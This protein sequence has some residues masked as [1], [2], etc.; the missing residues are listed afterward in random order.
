M[1]ENRL[2]EELG[3]VCNELDSF[4]VNHSHLMK[5]LEELTAEGSKLGSVA[6]DLNNYEIL[7]EQELYKKLRKLNSK[8][9]DSK[10]VAIN[11]KAL[12]QYDELQKNCD[13]FE[14]RMGETVR[15]KKE[16]TILLKDVC[17]KRGEAMLRNVRLIQEQFH[18]MFCKI[19]PQGTAE[20]I[21]YGKDISID[22]STD[23]EDVSYQKKHNY[24]AN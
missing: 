3:N 8:L 24:S 1:E 18:E 4:A 13:R 21:F 23:I 5:K 12:Q 11:Q 7:S 15:C 17:S 10:K 16:L 9:S 19:V 6:A 2:E 14:A 20:L 22:H